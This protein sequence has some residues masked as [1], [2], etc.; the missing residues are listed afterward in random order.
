M[1]FPFL[2][3]RLSPQLMGLSAAKLRE[4]I[5]AAVGIGFSQD[6]FGV[7]ME[8]SGKCSAEE[9]RN[10]VEAMIRKLFSIVDRHLKI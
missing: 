10:N 2:P 6:S 8:F 4:L 7:I 5:A 9:A 3:A 1:V